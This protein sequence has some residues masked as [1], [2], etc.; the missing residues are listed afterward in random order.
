MLPLYAFHNMYCCYTSFIYM[1]CSYTF[2]RYMCRY[3]MN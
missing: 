2:F 3:Y 1:Y